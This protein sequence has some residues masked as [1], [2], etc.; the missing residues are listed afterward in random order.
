YSS[1]ADIAAGDATIALVI[2]HSAADIA[3]SLVNLGWV[4]GTGV[5]YLF[6]T[7]GGFI[8]VRLDLNNGGSP[9][10]VTKAT[11]APIADVWYAIV[12]RWDKSEGVMSVSTKPLDGLDSPW[13]TVT[14][15]GTAG[16]D[17]W[18]NTTATAVRFLSA[19]HAGSMIAD[20]RVWSR[21][22]EESELELAARDLDLESADDMDGLV[23]WISF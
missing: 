18:Q 12:I 5:P 13:E 9:S 8:Q 3:G 16:L 1:A 21:H 11:V 2:R 10:S 14:Q 4:G 15:A 23:T 6:R 22:L 7:N 19:S 20:F 17:I